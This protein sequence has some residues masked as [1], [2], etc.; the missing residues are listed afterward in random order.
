LAQGCQP[1]SLPLCFQRVAPSCGGAAWHHTC[2]ALSDMAQ[3]GAVDEEAWKCPRCPQ[4]NDDSQEKCTNCGADRPEDALHVPENELEKFFMWSRKTWAQIKK[5]YKWGGAEKQKDL[6]P[7]EKKLEDIIEIIKLYKHIETDKDDEHAVVIWVDRPV[8]DLLISFVIITNTITIGI[9]LDD[10]FGKTTR[11]PGWIAIEVI[12]CCV[13]MSEVALKIKYHTWRWIG[14]SGWNI[15][16]VIIATLAVLDFPLKIAGVGGGLRMLSLL[17]VVGMLRLLKV[18][19]IYRS[20][21]ELRLIMQGL[22]GSLGMLC[23]TVAILIIFLYVSA[24]FTTSS[25]GRSEDFDDFSKLSNGWD[26]DALFGSVGKSMFTLLQCMTRD[27]WSSN[28]ARFVIVRQWYMSIFFVCFMLASTY[29]LLNLVVSVIVEQTLTAARAQESRMHAREERQQRAELEGLGEI[30]RMSDAD[31]S[32]D[33]DI[34]EFKKALNAK[35]SEVSWRMKVLDLPAE[36]CAR[37]FT[38]ID[39]SGTRTLSC[40]EFIEGCTKLKGPAK[41][42]DLLAITAQA[43]SLSQK[44]DGL[45]EDLQMAEKMLSELDDISVRITNRF[46][47]ALSSSHKKRAKTTGGSAPV[48]PLHPPGVAPT[49]LGSAIGLDLAH[50]NRPLLPVFPN[51]LN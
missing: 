35:D 18:I 12:Y 26:V 45:A 2:P 46:S 47:P 34:D 14:M 38:V 15:F 3:Y 48:K 23:W 25:I 32:G 19:R 4:S 40:E 6:S 20:L 5:K 10:Q 30:F 42:R 31:G 37:L 51:L 36:E 8:F 49:K 43:D 9:E 50:G 1:P 41:S 11:A 28:V 27:S 21:K 17:R 39:G 7:K 29:G 16:T 24:V 13:W 33:L 22:I 44:M